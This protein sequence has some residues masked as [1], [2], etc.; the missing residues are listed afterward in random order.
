M[1]LVSAPAAAQRSDARPLPPSLAR[2]TSGLLL[3]TLGFATLVGFAGTKHAF[4]ARFDWG[5]AAIAGTAIGTV[6]LAGFT[7]TL[8]WMTNDEARA[9]RDLATLT[10]ADQLARERPM[11]L[12]EV[13]SYIPAAT[14]AVPGAGN[15]TGRLVVRLV[16]AGLGPALDCAIGGVT[17][18]GEAVATSR[19]THLAP[20]YDTP[21][22]AFVVVVDRDRLPDTNEPSKVSLWGD[23][24]RSPVESARDHVDGPGACL[25]AIRPRGWGHP[26]EL[27]AGLGELGFWHPFRTPGSRAP[28]AG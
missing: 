28:R 4:T 19:F 8:A 10:R 16:N 27:G 20:G 5:L 2:W 24:S 22:I 23:I 26:G 18:R 7:S 25:A 14:E 9:T 15:E 6:L 12:V 3:L 13:T 21:A 11:V 1:Q 17:E